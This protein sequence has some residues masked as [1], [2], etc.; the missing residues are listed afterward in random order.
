MLCDASVTGAAA[1]RA[2]VSCLADRPARCCIPFVSCGSAD[3]GPE[4]L[5]CCA[6]RPANLLHV[7]GL[8]AAACAGVTARVD[9]NLT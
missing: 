9:L 3:A 6:V 1:V 7:R 2:P 4:T 8:L 5:G